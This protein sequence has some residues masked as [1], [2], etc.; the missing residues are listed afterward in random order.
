MLSS[1]SDPKAYRRYR[2]A[3][4]TLHPQLH[5]AGVPHRGALPV[6]EHVREGTA[7]DVDL[8]DSVDRQVR[9]AAHGP[10]HALLIERYPLLVHDRPSGSG[11]AYVEPG[12][13]AYLLAA[14]G[15]RAATALLWE[16]LA[17]STPDEPASIGYVT[18]ENEWAVDVGLAARM[19]L[20]TH[21]YL[22]LRGIARPP[23]PYL[24]S[25]HFL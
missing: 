13:G 2:L 4:F 19:E 12:G 10:D 5:L 15:R 22:A 18:A 14:T 3:G 16:T 20:H 17:A 7:A 6:V 1:S 9:A 21:G 25:R 23:R 24:P 11:Y 8:L